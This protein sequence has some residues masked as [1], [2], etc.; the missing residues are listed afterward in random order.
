MSKTFLDISNAAKMSGLSTR[1]FNRIIQRYKLPLIKFC[2]DGTPFTNMPEGSVASKHLILVRTVERW[3]KDIQ[4]PEY[5]RKFK[6]IPIKKGANI[7]HEL[8]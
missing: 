8:A 6:P 3:M 2:G 4:N 7:R 5:V 1:H